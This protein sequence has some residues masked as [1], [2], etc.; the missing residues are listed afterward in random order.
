[1]IR[2]KHR[3]ALRPI[4][5]AT[6]GLEV[7]LSLGAL[8]GGLALMIGPR[9]EIIP[10]QVASLGGSPFDTYFLPGL[11][12]FGVLGVGPL[13]AAGLAWAR[14]PVAAL[15]AVVIGIG[16]LIWLTVE[17]A[18]IGYTNDPPLQPIY[19]V[20]GLAIVGAGLRWLRQ[21]PGSSEQPKAAR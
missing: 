18:I 7:L 3:T 16:L 21:P 20:L 12:L 13:V 11:I 10:L 5:R 1:M 19:L 17:I 6:I 15:A 4:A 14:M 8:A 9:G 2:N